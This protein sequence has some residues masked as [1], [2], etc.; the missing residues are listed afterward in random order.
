MYSLVEIT[1]YTDEF[2]HNKLQPN[3]HMKFIDSLI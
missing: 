2:E 1:K 3:A